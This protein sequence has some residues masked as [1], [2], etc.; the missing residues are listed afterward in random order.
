MPQPHA[1]APPPPRPPRR[2]P[3]RSSATLPSL[4]PEPPDPP[5]PLT[6]SPEPLEGVGRPD[7]PVSDTSAPFS[8][9][10]G[11]LRA[12]R[13]ATLSPAR[14]GAPQQPQDLFALASAA[15]RAEGDELFGPSPSLTARSRV[16]PGEGDGNV[17]EARRRLR[18][19]YAV[20]RDEDDK[21]QRLLEGVWGG[22]GGQTG[23]SALTPRVESP[24][25][26]E[27]WRRG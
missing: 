9:R 17:A 6:A 22:L 13:A 15:Q 3:I 23:A 8:I 12:S 26:D 5:Q 20:G 14:P 7:S 11:H 18:E 1:G 19:K 2:H 24:T 10:S 25:A 16:G 27:L 21:F 4:P